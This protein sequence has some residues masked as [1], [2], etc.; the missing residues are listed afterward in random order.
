MISTPRESY[1]SKILT[2]VRFFGVSQDLICSNNCLAISL[3]SM[4]VLYRNNFFFPGKK[5]M[6]PYP[7]VIS[8]LLV[9][10]L[11]FQGVY[12]VLQSNYTL[13]DYAES[14]YTL[15]GKLGMLDLLDHKHG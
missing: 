4:I 3:L 6:P 10:Y 8:L 11:S 13:L 9:F 15:V 12:M 5:C 7:A 1:P 14:S 2:P